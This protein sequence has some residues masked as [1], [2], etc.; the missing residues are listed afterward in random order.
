M[1]SRGGIEKKKEAFSGTKGDEAGDKGSRGGKTV[2]EGGR[3]ETPARVK[4]HS[5]QK[6]RKKRM[7]YY[8]KSADT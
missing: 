4:L 7:H 3:E 1:R 2:Q 5:D 8:C 6:A